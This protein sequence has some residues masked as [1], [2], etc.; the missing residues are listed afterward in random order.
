[1]IKQPTIVQVKDQEYYQQIDIETGQPIGEVKAVDVLIKEVPR[2]GFEITYLAAI[3]SMI[4]SIGNKKMQV[5][6]YLLKK[7]D[8]SNKITETAREIAAGSGCSY[9]TVIDTLQILE[10]A[11]IIARK[12][13][14]VMISP[15]LAHKGNAQKERLLL[16]KFFEIQRNTN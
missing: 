5:V 2:A 6:K 12:T 16:T 13:G 11:G 10:Q 3:C 15:K 4:D 7:R 14:V 9:R 1:M 8:T